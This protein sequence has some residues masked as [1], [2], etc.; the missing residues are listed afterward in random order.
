[1]QGDIDYRNIRH[2]RAATDSRP[3]PIG[4]MNQNLARAEHF[5][6]HGN[7]TKLHLAGGREGHDRAG[8]RPV[9]AG[10]KPGGVMPPIA[11]IAANRYARRLPS[12]GHARNAARGGAEGKTLNL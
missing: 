7:M 12:V 6:H 5:L 3:A 11:A 8:F 4:V 2:D 1:M 10:I 9:P